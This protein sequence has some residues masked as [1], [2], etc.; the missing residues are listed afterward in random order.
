MIN[1]IKIERYYPLVGGVVASLI[2]YK[3]AIKIPTDWKEF[4]TAIIS[5]GAIFAGFIA[6][7]IAI[8]MALPSDGVISR[9]KKSGYINDLTIYLEQ[10]LY[11]T[12]IFV[13]FCLIGFYGFHTCLIYSSIIGG[14]GFYSILCFFRASSLMIKILKY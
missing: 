5:V 1:S 7:A 2:F 9:F 12:V 4:L 11:G 8:L 6:T 3:L 10:A 14:F 13:V